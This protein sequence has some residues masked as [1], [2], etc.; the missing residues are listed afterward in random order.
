MDV[1]AMSGVLR[2]LDAVPDP[3]RFNVTYTLRAAAPR[4]CRLDPDALQR[5]LITAETVS[6]IISAPGRH[7]P[8]ILLAL[9]HIST[10]APCHSTGTSRNFVSDSFRPGRPAIATHP[11]HPPSPPQKSRS[12]RLC[13]TCFMT[14]NTCCNTSNTCW[15]A[16][17]TRWTTPD[18]QR[19]SSH[20]QPALPVQPR[21]YAV[22]GPGRDEWDTMS[23]GLSRRTRRHGPKTRVA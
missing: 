3:R 2:Y 20:T 19:K 13:N 11:P 23:R 15:K 14:C 18:A 5:C 10:V 4:C 16:C 17:N 7:V 8:P 22:A 12:R 1:Q 6:D 21:C 9:G